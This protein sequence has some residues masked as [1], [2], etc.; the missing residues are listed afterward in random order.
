[1]WNWGAVE[2]LGFPT[3]VTS[4]TMSTID[5]DLIIGTGANWASKYPGTQAGLLGC[6]ATETTV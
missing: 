5:P 1:M 2:F 3:D 6:D 4:D